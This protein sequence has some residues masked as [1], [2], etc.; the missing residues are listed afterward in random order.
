MAASAAF[1]VNGSTPTGAVAVT[2]STTVTLALL[3]TSGVNSVAWSIVGNHSSG[4][5]NPTITPAGSPVGA[6]ASFP[7]PAGAGQAYL[8]RCVVNGGVDANGDADGALTKQ[9]IVGVNDAFAR[10][11]LATGENLE[12]SA[13]HGWTEHINDLATNFS[14][15]SAAIAPCRLAATGNIANLS[16]AGANMDGAALVVADRVLLPLQTTATQNGVYV[17]SSLT[18]TV[19]TRATDMA[20][21]ASVNAGITVAVQAGGTWQGSTWTLRGDGAL[22]VGT[23][24]LSFVPDVDRILARRFG[25]T[26][27]GTTDDTAALTLARTAA[28]S[29]KVPLQLPSG[30]IRYTS[31]LVIDADDEAILGSGIFAEHGSA[32]GTR[33]LFDGTGP[34]ILIGQDVDTALTFTYRT[35]LAGFSLKTPT[36]CPFAIRA[37]CPGY[38]RLIDVAVNGPLGNTNHCV[39]IEQGVDVELARVQITGDN[40]TYAADRTTYANGVRVFTAL[41]SPSTTVSLNK[42]YLHRCYQ[43]LVTDASYVTGANVTIEGCWRALQNGTNGNVALHDSWVE[44]CGYD[45]TVAAFGYLSGGSQTTLLACKLVGPA[46]PEFAFNVVGSARLQIAGGD[47]AMS[48]ATPKLVNP[49]DYTPGSGYVSVTDANLNTIAYGV[50]YLAGAGVKDRARRYV[51]SG[52][53]EGVVYGSVGD[54]CLRIDG[55]AG[56]TLYVKESGAVTNTGWVAMQTPPALGAADTVLR[57][58]SGATAFECAKLTTSNLDASAA[59]VASQLAAGGANTVLQGGTPNTWTATPTVTTLNATTVAAT[60]VTATGYLAFGA[61]PADAGTIRFSAASTIMGEAA[62]TGTDVTIVDFTDEAALTFGDTDITVVSL[63]GA[64]VAINGASDTMIE[65]T[66]VAAGRRVVALCRGSALTT[67]QMP[68]DTGDRVVYLADCATAPTGTPVGG[69][70]ISSQSGDIFWTDA[71]G[72]TSQLN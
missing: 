62:P 54:E 6:T 40:E 18:P 23:D 33:L 38:L 35:R 47:Y 71:A 69:G 60:N 26:A 11:P 49:S 70:I 24:A 53:P 37:W 25:V 14:G 48:H 56:S 44:G 55:G 59:I 72:V 7:M 27:D 1:T 21:A 20:A 41:G 10:V 52:S 15:S 22:T 3:S 17:V 4:A 2:A 29:L 13:T 28:R 32:V 30:T 19:L 67:T 66:E 65:T 9:H 63:N 51:C 68:A 16:N 61:D 36:T 43:G 45:A 39:S 8:V 50:S 46:A 31:T 42:V 34:A 5:V 12:R 57:V 64:T 58:N